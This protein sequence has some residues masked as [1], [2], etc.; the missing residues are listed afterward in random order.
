MKFNE[1][2]FFLGTVIT[3]FLDNPYQEIDFKSY[4]N[5]ILPYKLGK[6]LSDLHMS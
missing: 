1:V 3:R 5:S 4:L 6:I 2:H